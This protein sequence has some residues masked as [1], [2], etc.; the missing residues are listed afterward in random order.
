VLL[1]LYCMLFSASLLYAQQDQGAITGTVQDATGAVVPGAQVTLKNT[2]NGLVL[3]THADSSGIYN[4]SPVKIGNF[5]VSANA[6][7][8]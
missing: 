7:G 8:F 1:A 4:F 5:T 6:P 2:D 3:Q